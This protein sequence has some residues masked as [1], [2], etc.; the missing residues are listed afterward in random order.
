MNEQ[1]VALITGSGTGVGRACA[2]RF[3]K[4]GFGVVVNYSRSEAEAIETGAEVE[5]L[6]GKALVHQCDV[7]DDQ[8]VAEMVGVIQ[9]T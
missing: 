1:R 7:S 9:R 4:L 3:A 2:L 6:G 5:H 8:A